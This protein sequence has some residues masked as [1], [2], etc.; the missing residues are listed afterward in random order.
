ML[1]E[2]FRYAGRACLGHPKD[3]RHRV[4][5]EEKDNES[6]RRFCFFWMINRMNALPREF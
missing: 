1:D 3:R 6:Q 2:G 5:K 4:R